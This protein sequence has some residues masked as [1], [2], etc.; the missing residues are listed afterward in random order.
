MSAGFPGY[1]NK[2]NRYVIEKRQNVI[3]QPVRSLVFFKMQILNLCICVYK[4]L[5][6]LL[7]EQPCLYLM[8]N[9]VGDN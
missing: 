8:I 9:C 4:G 2:A 5:F 1:A 6:T 3:P 7:T